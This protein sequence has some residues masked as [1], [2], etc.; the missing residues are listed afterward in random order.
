M[1][2]I[3]LINGT[4]LRALAFRPL[5]GG[6]SAV[7]RSLEFGRTLPGVA[8]TVVF[9]SK[10]ADLPEGARTVVRP[11][12]SVP[13]LLAEM[14][15]AAEGC[16][17]VFYFFADC[18]FLDAA[19]AARMH[20]NHVKYW[21]DYTFADG[22]PY[23]ITPEILTRDTISRLRGM[24]D[25]GGAPRR[26]TLFSILKKDINSFDIETEISPHDMRLMRLSL[27]ADSERNFLLLSRIVAGGARDAEAACAFLLDK[28]ESHRTLPTFFPIQIVERCPQACSYCP[29]PLVGG[30]ILGKNGFMPVDVFSRLVRRIADF[31]GDAVIDISL[32]GEPSLHPRIFDIIAS[33]LDVAGIDLVIETSGIGC[34]AAW[35]IRLD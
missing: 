1:K 18:P 7:D 33:A 24:A 8:E 15:T 23:G 28:Q 32:W 9:L 12:W 29:Y 13:D 22:Y 11:S 6:R 34:G 10:P 5:L 27:T 19:L 4:D 35:A 26:D 17:S 30:N 25:A 21:A 2:N 16:D 3:A 14:S 20:A 31:A